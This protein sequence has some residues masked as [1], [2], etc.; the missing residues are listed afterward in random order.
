MKV[1]QLNQSTN[2]VSIKEALSALVDHYRLQSKLNEA[3]LQK[4]WSNMMGVSI[5]KHTEE[6]RLRKGKLYVR[7][8]SAALK[9]ELS[10]GKEKIKKL[11][12]E[13]LGQEAIQEVVIV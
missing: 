1:M 3:K 9:Q 12:N 6:L 2:Q 4:S 7:I 5:A 8:N 13:E 11:L 10:F